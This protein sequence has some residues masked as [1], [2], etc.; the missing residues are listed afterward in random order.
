MDEET[1]KIIAEQMKKLPKDVVTAI[2]SVDYKTKLQEITKRQRLLIDQAGKLEMETTLIMIGLEPLADFVGNLAR[3]MNV[4]ELRA[5]EIAL[6]VSENIFKPI[7]NSLQKMNEE[8]QA[9]EAGEQKIEEVET[10]LNR[11]QILDEIENPILNRPSIR[12]VPVEQP[13]VS[14]EIEIRPV[15]E[16]KSVPGETVK[17][18]IKNVEPNIFEAKMTQTVITPPQIVNVETRTKLPEIEKKDTYKSSDPY[19]EPLV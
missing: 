11:D 6:D 3:E 12:P 16:L 4:N 7:R 1:Q 17:D 2:V 15:Q 18:V 10:T 9:E 5:R 8:T 14:T 13:Q 19:R